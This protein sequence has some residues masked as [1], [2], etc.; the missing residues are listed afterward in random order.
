[1]I[2][3]NRKVFIL[4]FCLIGCSI[5]LFTVVNEF[6]KFPVRTDI[7][8]DY[9]EKM[10]VPEIDIILYNIDL[11]N[12]TALYLKYPEKM[13]N[14]CEF[15]M[16]SANLENN[17]SADCIKFLRSYYE[18]SYHVANMLTVGDVERLNVE[19][20]IIESE[21]AFADFIRNDLC[22]VKKYFSAMNTFIRVSCREDSKPIE[23][24][25]MR[26]IATDN[27]FCIQHHIY[28][29]FGVRFAHQNSS[30]DS[31]VFNYL[32]VEREAGENV[33]TIL[34]Y[35]ETT[36]ESRE[37]PYQTNCRHYKKENK[38]SQCLREKISHLYPGVVEFEDVIQV[39]QFPS[40]FKFEDLKTR[41][42]ETL[43]L[44]QS[45]C[46]KLVKQ[47]QCIEKTYR[48]RGRSLK[49]KGSGIGLICLDNLIDFNIILKTYPKSTFT[50][51]L[52]YISSILGIWFGIS[53]YGKLIDGFVFPTIT[54][55]MSGAITSKVGPGVEIST[56]T[57]EHE[58][59]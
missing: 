11:L 58:T 15:L 2:F 19:S 34:R 36:I 59:V 53:I 10:I 5:H 1:M 50:E 32:E 52:I 16:K 40:H 20:L 49:E 9:P 14:A 4:T 12:M 56:M 51:L 17:S 41:T 33:F 23:K 13:E 24:R 47:P 7:I 28:N 29:R 42:N 57:E 45:E 31:Y 18:K 43:S 30:I 26:N 3:L 21:S 35:K 54:T 37:W 22:A 39:G 25:L 48:T 8:Y 44:I 6:L 46:T 38:F 55:Q 27:H